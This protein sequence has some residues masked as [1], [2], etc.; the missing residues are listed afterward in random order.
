MG[1]LDFIFPKK[2]VSCK[3]YGS[4]LC[5]NCFIYI[6]FNPRQNCLVCNKVS[7]NNL[8]H[9]T[10]LKKYT[11]DGCFS[12][13]LYNK[14]TQRLINNFKQ[15]PFLLDLKTVL[16]ELF[17]ESIIQNENFNTK[18]QKNDWILV[19]VPVSAEVYRKRGYNHAEILANNLSVSLKIKTFNILGK[20]K[21]KVFVK[22]GF[23]INKMN[24]F[25]IDDVVKT[26]FTLKQTAKVLK[27]S[28]AKR[29]FGLTLARS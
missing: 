25:L 20:S 10:C 3:K 23:E 17:Y 15:K 12:A 13:L 16:S 5:T 19:P 21:N 6:S 26:G 8:T 28:G 11:I 9:K 27:E 1:L 14:I 22:K 24:I 2:C 18:L 7:F 29:V 4:Y